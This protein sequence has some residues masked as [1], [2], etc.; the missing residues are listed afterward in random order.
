MA[1]RDQIALIDLDGTVADY[2][3]AL[4]KEMEKLRA[5]NEPA[6]LD[7][8]SRVDAGFHSEEKEPPHIEARRRLIT[9]VP[10]FWSGLERL[11][12]G[13]EVIA[14]LRKIG[15]MLH[16]LTKGPARNDQ[17]WMEKVRWCRENLSDAF[18]TVTMDKSIVYGR[19][20]FD[21]YPAYFGEWLAVRPRGLVVC[22][23]QPWNEQFRVGGKEEHPRIFRYD[24][25]NLAGLK[26]VLEHA[27]HRAPGEP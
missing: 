22:N 24:Q 25:T 8:Y 12:S 14:E 2:D 11:Q 27:Y 7:R 18:V 13:F 23:A 10:G 5:P 15:F 19:V 3:T 21:D 26:V 20:L 9:K 1:D 4:K 6:Y 17:A 16:V